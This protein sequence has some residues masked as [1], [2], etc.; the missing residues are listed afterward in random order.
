MKILCAVEFGVRAQATARVA[1]DL[2]RRT[3]GSVELVHVVP[4]R[5]TT[6]LAMAVDAAVLDDSVRED[7]RTR[8]E[9]LGREVAAAGVPVTTHLAEGDIEREVMNRAQAIGADLVVMGAHGRPALE[10]LMLGSASERTVRI[11]D[12]PVLIVPPGVEPSA[13]PGGRP[14]QVLVALDGRVASDGALEFVRALR[15]HTACDVTVL[16][17]Y[18]PL[19]EIAR[20]GLRGTRD[21]FAPDPEIVADLDR[22]L[23]LQVGALPGQ[24]TTGFSIQ[25]TWG[26]PAERLLAAAASASADLLV[27]GAESRHGLSRVSN[28]P[29]AERVARH[30]RHVPVVFAPKPAGRS[31]GARPP[32]GIFTVLAATD[33]SPSG[34]QAVPYAYEMLA[35]HG[36]VVEL[37][38]VHEHGVPSPA[39]AYDTSVGNLSPVRRAEVEGAL[40]ALVPADAEALGIATHVR[41]IDGGKAATD[42]VQA[43]ERLAVDAI[44]V[45][46]HG[47]G[48]TRRALLGSVSSGVVGA[49]HRPV[50]VVP[51]RGDG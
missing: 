35:G 15:R 31:A 23:R 20:L 24:G 34:N 3:S 51:P 2:A 19:E 44:V 7:G 10:R 22:T 48:R 4:P 33:L 25:P 36:G 6:V 30:A 28:P 47:H 17:L 50:M 38:T 8:L 49:S 42:I 13:T 21:L 43:A 18:W 39:Y 32:R 27:M 40:R 5:A 16:R 11:A 12:R 46:T 14:L 1:R 45:G 29:V 26:E 9:A 41:V 37:C